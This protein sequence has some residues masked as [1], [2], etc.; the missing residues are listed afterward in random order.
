MRT[1]VRQLPPPHLK[2]PHPSA[3]T[4]SYRFVDV[5]SQGN[6]YAGAV[7]DRLIP[8]IPGFR[9]SAAFLTSLSANLRLTDDDLVPSPM[10]TP[11]SMRSSTAHHLPPPSPLSVP[12]STAL[13]S[14]AELP[15]STTTT[16][17][18]EPPSNN[19]E[20]AALPELRTYAATTPADRIAGLKLVADSVA[21]QRQLTSRELIFHPLHLAALTLVLALVAQYLYA[22]AADLVLVG[23]TCGGVVMACLAAVRWVCG[24][25]IFHAETINWEWL[26]DDEVVVVRWGEEVIGALVLGW[27]EE[28]GGA[29]RARGKGARR[30]LGLV[31]GWTVQQKYRGKGVGESLLEEA[32][33]VAGER[34]VKGVEF[35]EEHANSLRILPAFY[36]GFLDRRDARAARALE[37]VASAKGSFGKR[38]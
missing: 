25:Y 36:N 10:S 2:L 13:A 32:V 7:G 33:R 11:P 22:S 28:G 34:G 31:R 6:Q 1:M 12:P 18:N 14:S 35:A 23:T 26:G 5:V 3:S 27:S 38:R 9:T 20:L 17:T 4:P 29:K 19:P 37:K 30:G 24:G 21:Q 16:S 8:A 15:K